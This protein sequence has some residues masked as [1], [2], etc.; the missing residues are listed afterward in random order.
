MSVPSESLV[1][2]GAGTTALVDELI[3]AGYTAIRAFDISRAALDR[4]RTKLGERAQHVEFIRADARTVRFPTQID[5]WH[6]RATFHFLTDPID[7][8]EYVRSVV[9]ALRPGGHV[10]LATFAS[11][12]PEQCSGLAVARHSPASLELLFGEKFELIES[13]ER[14][15]LTP[16][17][18]PQRFLHAVL[19]SRSV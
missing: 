4:L 19:R 8:V 11:D 5:L 15:H 1:L 6:D 18:S 10:V 17:G 2:I 13:F 14:D 12:G 16:G 9:A 3:D 7:Q